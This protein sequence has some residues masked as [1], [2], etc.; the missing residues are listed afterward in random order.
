MRRLSQDTIQQ[1]TGEQV[2]NKHVQ[3]VSVEVEQSEIIKKTVQRK[4]DHP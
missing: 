4:S 2:V 3:Q 1:R